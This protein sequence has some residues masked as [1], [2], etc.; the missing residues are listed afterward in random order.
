LFSIS[1]ELLT[2]WRN[3]IKESKFQDIQDDRIKPLYTMSREE[4]NQ[5]KI[6]DQSFLRKLR[7]DNKEVLICPYFCKLG[8]KSMMWLMV[9]AEISYDG[10]IRSTNVRPFIPRKYLRPLQPM[11]KQDLTISSLEKVNQYWEKHIFP[12]NLSWDQLLHEIQLF[13]GNVFDHKVHFS[14]FRRLDQVIVIDAQGFEDQDGASK[15]V[16]DFYDNVLG[17]R[18]PTSIIKPLGRHMLTLDEQIEQTT[19]SDHHTYSLKHKGQMNPE[20]G[21]TPSQRKA[22]HHFLALEE[23][24]CLSIEGPPGTG[25]T[26]LLQSVIASL[27]VDRA[28]QESDKPP[29]I[30]ASGT[31]NLA[32]KNI[33][34]M[35]ADV[36]V[37][38]NVENLAKRWISG[39][40]SFGSFCVATSRQKEFQ[41]YQLLIRGRNLHKVEF[42]TNWLDFQQIDSEQYAKLEADF[43][44]QCEIYWNRKIDNLIE[45]KSLIHHHL[46]KTIQTMQ[47]PLHNLL[48]ETTLQNEQQ[49][50]QDEYKIS[51]F[52]EGLELFQRYQDESQFQLQNVEK[53]HEKWFQRKEKN[54]SLLIRWLAELPLI[55]DKVQTYLKKGNRVFVER[56]LSGTIFSEYTDDTIER[57]LKE[58]E[59]RSKS[60]VQSWQEKLTRQKSLLSRYHQM[61]KDKKQKG[62][63]W[64][65]MG[66]PRDLEDAEVYFDCKY[67]VLAFWLATHYW[68]ARFL[69]QV[70]QRLEQDNQVF[71]KLGDFYHEL[72]MITPCLISTMHSA[73][74]FFKE[75]HFYLH[76]IADLLIVDEASQALPEL[77]FP[78]FALAQKALVVGDTKQLPPIPSI[79]VKQDQLCLQQSKLNQKVEDIDKL[80]IR[81]TNGSVIKWANR[82]TRYVDENSQPF[83][84]QEHFRCHS[85]IAHYIN[86]EFYERQLQVKTKDKQLYQLPAL[87][88]AQVNGIEEPLG[89]S[90]VNHYEAACI[91]LW[92][93]RF[94]QQHHISIEH[95]KE[96]VAV[97]TPFKA[98]AN[99]IRSYLKRFHLTSITVDTVHSLQGMQREVILFSPTYTELQNQPLFFDRNDYIL[100]VAVSRAKQS[101]LIF[102]EMNCFGINK[103]Q[104]S[105]RLKHYCL[106]ATKQLLLP[107]EEQVNHLLDRSSIKKAEVQTINEFHFFAPVNNAIIAQNVH[108]ASIKS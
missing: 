17:L 58:L 106:D 105:A 39:V 51:S 42:T 44:R 60:I 13:I 41:N 10:S 53:V 9:S 19:I 99:V 30:L 87:A 74:R 20:Y 66:I 75:R 46:K 81:G 40:E 38:D 7:I 23:G 103:D 22:I 77:A 79:T 88:F 102:G 67:R 32:I 1:T 31:T 61:L 4:F 82:L 84:L 72:A 35:F 5:G 73:P 65:S 104:P 52:E 18:K 57:E 37:M 80:F 12:E 55:G 29:M 24:N 107:S 21:L 43:L 25:K 96:V 63:Q 64:K 97:L 15:W 78:V 3:N 70:K 95:Q 16:Q 68:E 100:N 90:R 59:K 36:P 33:L 62:E 8:N 11:D 93:Q 34:D 91:A 69:L 49:S 101:F 50:Q 92:V 28:C 54:R 27:W 2:Y 48:E 47:E 94:F 85:K 6:K 14:N 108:G 89:S 26:T 76:G 98:Q 71:E 56:H 45:A 83:M 86:H